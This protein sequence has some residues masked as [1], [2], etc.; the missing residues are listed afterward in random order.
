MR[1]KSA[2]EMATR[3]IAAKDGR[4]KLTS[5]DGSGNVSFGIPEFIDIPGAKYD[6]EIGILGLEAS[7]TLERPGYRVKK[8]RIRPGRVSRRHV[9][10]REDAVAFMRQRFGVKVGEDE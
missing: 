8:R 5:F 2:E 1:G 9:V 10:S 3:L 4:L 7:V 6:P